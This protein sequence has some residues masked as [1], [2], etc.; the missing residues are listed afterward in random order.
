MKSI[1]F[2][3]FWKTSSGVQTGFF[4]P[5]FEQ[6][7]GEEVNIV[8]DPT[9]WV[10]LEIHSVFPP[11]G[12]IVRKAFRHFGLV[13][14]REIDWFEISPKSKSG[15][16]IWFTGEN[17]RPPLHL[18]FD[19][20]LSFE[21]ESVDTRNIYFPLWVLNI[22]WFNKKGIHGFVGVTPTQNE[23][24]NPRSVDKDGLK[25]RKFCASFIGNPENMRL[26]AI[27]A[28]GAIAKVD[29]FGRISGIHIKNKIEILDKYKFILAFENSNTPGYVTE[30]LL[31]A[32]LTG[33]IPIYWGLDTEGYFNENAFINFSNFRNFEALTS[34][35]EVLSDD[36][37]RISEILSQPILNKP[38]PIQDVV[39]K[40]SKAL[41]V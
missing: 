34:H 40:L 26:G 20:Y 39:R 32:Q 24:L 6:V 41:F 10:D 9:L 14:N 8:T 36:S 35:I 28:L 18:D 27:T 13:K 37:N 1:R 29:L 31:E 11:S 22:D 19:A 23:L 25:N 3:N 15:R 4:K 17:I 7:Y 2:I 16:K 21:S 33:A 30:K 38:F 12:G 5:L